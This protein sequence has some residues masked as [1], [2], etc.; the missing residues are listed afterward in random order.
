ML[1]A[2]TPRDLP[3]LRSIRLFWTRRICFRVSNIPFLMQ[4]K[5]W[6]WNDW[7]G[8]VKETILWKEHRFP[9]RSSLVSLLYSRLPP[10]WLVRA[11]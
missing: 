6:Q 5:D 3:I 9:V 4:T 8:R 1:L 7:E 11:P 10:F 2:S